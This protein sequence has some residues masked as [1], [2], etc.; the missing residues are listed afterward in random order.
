MELPLL[1]LAMGTGVAMVASVPNGVRYR[2]RELSSRYFGMSQRAFAALRSRPRSRR[3]RNNRSFVNAAN[4]GQRGPG[5]LFKP[6]RCCNSAT[7]CSGAARNLRGQRR[8]PRMTGRISPRFHAEIIV[9]LFDEYQ[10]VRQVTERAGIMLSGSSLKHIE[11]VGKYL[12]IDLQRVL[13]RRMELCVNLGD[14]V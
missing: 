14:D 13:P 10:D 1:T 2:L 3:L 8:L 9:V 11:A 4:A 12:P 7:N 5:Q 6:K